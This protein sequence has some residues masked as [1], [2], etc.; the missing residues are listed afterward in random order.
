ME[1]VS[2]AQQNPQLVLG[3]GGAFL[4]LFVV[5]VFVLLKQNDKIKKAESANTE[6]RDKIVELEAQKAELETKLKTAADEGAEKDSRISEMQASMGDL[7]QKMEEMENSLA[8]RDAEIAELKNSLGSAER[9]LEEAV[10]ERDKLKYEYL[11]SILYIKLKS[12]ADEF[13]TDFSQDILK[14]IATMNVAELDLNTAQNIF[15]MALELHRKSTEG[16]EL[17]DEQA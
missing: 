3:F 15:N 12:L 14:G 2:W 13:Y 17:E 11:I 7:Q 6:N 1:L 9:N 8:D 16:T 5:S 4:F 10:E